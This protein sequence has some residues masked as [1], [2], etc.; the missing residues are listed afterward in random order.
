MFC[1]KRKHKSLLLKIWLEAVIQRSICLRMEEDTSALMRRTRKCQIN[2]EI[3]IN[4]TWMDFDWK[5][6]RDY[7]NI[8]IALSKY[9]CQTSLDT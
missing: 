5:L 7:K 8:I 4:E 3:G 6:D 1:Y 9:V 2:K